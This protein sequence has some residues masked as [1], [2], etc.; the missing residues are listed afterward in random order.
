MLWLWA[1][2]FTAVLAWSVIQPADYTIWFLEAFPAIAAAIILLAT[3]KR[4]PLTGLLYVLILAHAV[5]LMV[6]AH[7]TYAE[8]PLFDWIK[9]ATG[10]SR[11][12]YD[13]LGH[14]MQGFV[15]AIVAREILIRHAVIQGRC[16]L[17]F[18]VVCIS[19][20]ISALYELFEWFVAVFSDEAAD[21]FL[22]TQGYVWDTQS[23]MGLALLGAIVALLLLTR[24]H[25]RQLARLSH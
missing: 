3:R 14:F 8:V 16:W 5:V 20:A 21:A 6:G 13:K 17:A 1:A 25:D 11:N 23:D 2:I 12:N 4:F 19:L 10:G 15:P 18:I 9:E 22:G 7:Y 24:F